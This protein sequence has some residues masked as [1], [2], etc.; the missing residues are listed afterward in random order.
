MIT[1]L[2]QQ[3]HFLFSSC[4]YVDDCFH[5]WT[6]SEFQW[7]K[8]TSM[9]FG[10]QYLG[11]S[12]KGQ[13][14]LESSLPL[15]LEEQSI[16]RAIIY[17]GKKHKSV[18]DETTSTTDL[19]Y[20][21][22][23][24]GVLKIFGDSLVPGVEYKGVLASY[25][26]TAQELVKQ[27]LDRYGLPSS[28]H[29]QFV[30]CDVIGKCNQN[31]KIEGTSKHERIQKWSRVCC[32]VVAD[33]DRPLQHQSFWKPADG[34]SRR[35][36]I[37]RK[38]DV[39]ADTQTE[40][41]TSGLNENARK[42]SIAKLRPGAIPFFTPWK[43]KKLE[44][45]A[46]ELNLDGTLTRVQSQWSGKKNECNKFLNGLN[47][48]AGIQSQTS[49]SHI[50]QDH[51]LAPTH[52][53]FL[54]T[55]RCF[56][57]TSDPLYH[58]LDEKSTH[59]GNGQ[60]S[61]INSVILSAPD[62]SCKLCNLNV[63]C[64]SSTRVNGSRPTHNYCLEVVCHASANVKINGKIVSGRGFMY[65]GD[66]ISFGNYYVFMFKD[67]T[68]GNDVSPPWMNIFSSLDENGYGKVSN[69]YHGDV[70]P[71][72]LGNSMDDNMSVSTMES[73]GESSRE[74]FRF[75]Y[76]KEKEEELLKAIGAVIRQNYVEFSLSPAYLYS[77]CIEYACHQFDPHQIHNL[78]LRTLVVIR[79]SV[80]VGEIL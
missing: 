71:L 31:G 63:K 67:L 50:S 19:S 55:L 3:G 70:P 21:Q 7:K 68:T 54:L 22:C 42:I 5:G 60:G 80:S 75:A 59:V 12:N 24:P 45:F 39:I 53:P 51:N 9:P 37:R 61:N 73:N 33:T 11:S 27:A 17:P 15:Y 18:S 30:L 56:D 2:N 47:L 40:D 44:K 66:I 14:D 58:I 36:E 41:D 72:A 64:L 29:H 32:R 25:R 28:L 8:T 6:M 16:R 65:C 46:D 69:G 49:P 13:I 52:H 1:T 78:M 35:Y 57:V 10:L 38:S 76:S 26:S 74:R 77:M 4:E 62:I 34:F 48:D 20:D 23:S 43:N 79:E